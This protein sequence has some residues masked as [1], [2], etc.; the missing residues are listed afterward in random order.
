MRRSWCGTLLF[1][2]ASAALVS[3]MIGCAGSK[4]HAATA[5]NAPQGPYTPQPYGGKMAPDDYQWL[6][7]AKD[8]ASTRYST[9]DQINT[10]TVKNLKVAWTFNTATDRGQEAAPLI[11]NNTMYVVTPW[12]N[13][14]YA[15][16]LTRPGGPLKWK[17][18]PRPAAASKGV[19][20]CDWVNRG[21]SY[22]DGKIF[23]NT[24]DGYTVAVNATNGQQVWKTKI[25]DITRGESLTMAPLVV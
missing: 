6:R 11:V 15:L 1:F 16:D 18:D 24:L 2:I 12:P 4:S 3:S 21:A 14:L 7:P 9:L 23:Y 20:C 17:Y 8:Y 5:Q 22:D 19:A 10:D 25:G 13:L